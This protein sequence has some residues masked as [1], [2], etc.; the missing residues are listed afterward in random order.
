MDPSG[1]KWIDLQQLKEEKNLQQVLAPKSRNNRT[2]LEATS[3]Q[4]KSTP[5]DLTPMDLC[6]LTTLT[7][8]DKNKMKDVHLKRISKGI[9]INPK[10]RNN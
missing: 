4:P 9:I 8:K 6:H 2:Y 5:Q 1:K 3:S 10:K 7:A